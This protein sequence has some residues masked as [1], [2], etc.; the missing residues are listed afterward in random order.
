M[1]KDCGKYNINQL[2]SSCHCL[3]YLFCTVG[4]FLAELLAERFAE[5]CKLLDYVHSPAEDRCY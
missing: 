3:D 5:A 2:V 1:M 4:Y